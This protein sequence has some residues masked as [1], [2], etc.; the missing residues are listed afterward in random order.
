MVDISKLHASFRDNPEG[1]S[2][3]IQNGKFLISKGKERIKIQLD[4]GTKSQVSLDKLQEL[5]ERFRGVDSIQI[6]HAITELKE[7][8]ITSLTENDDPMPLA[9]YRKVKRPAEPTD[10]ELGVIRRPIKYKTKPFPPARMGNEKKPHEVSDSELNITNIRSSHSVSEDLESDPEEAL[11][12][13]FEKVFPD[14]TIHEYIELEAYPLKDQI[15]AISK[16][17]FK[18]SQLEEAVKVFEK[19][20]EMRKVSIFR[21]KGVEAAMAELRSK[22]PK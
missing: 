9:M 21:R 5:A 12:Q 17:A 13:L 10:E 7:R 6:K 3:A 8:Y 18:I 2:E 14:F 15:L 16:G 19:L 22:L 1:L 20:I 11:R 4:D